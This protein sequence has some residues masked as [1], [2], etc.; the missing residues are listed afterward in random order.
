[1]ILVGNNAIKAPHLATIP[2]RLLATG[3]SGRQL[4]DKPG[5]TQS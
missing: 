3:E 1:M 2:L 4:R 5:K